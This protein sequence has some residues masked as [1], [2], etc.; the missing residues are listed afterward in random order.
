M[1]PFGKNARVCFI[2]DSI[3]NFNIYVAYIYD[4][5]AVH[6]AA[7]NVR[8]YNCGISGA[9]AQTLVKAY[10]RDVMP[11][12][13]THAVIMAGVN[14]CGRELLQKEIT[15]QAYDT[16]RARLDGYK[17]SI[18]SLCGKAER[19]NAR[20]ILCT[21]PPI[22]EYTPHPAPTFNGGYALMAAYADFIRKFAKERKY[23]LCDVFARLSQ[24][25]CEN[26]LYGDDRIHPNERGQACIAK[27][28]LAA[29]GE[30]HDEHQ[31]ISEK[32][33]VWRDRVFYY[34]RIICAEHLILGGFDTPPDEGAAEMREF[35]KNKSAPD[36]MRKMAEIYIK[37][38]PRQAALEKEAYGE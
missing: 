4:Y 20:V 38:K 26:V 36:F 25:M 7:D 3:T 10:E 32:S 35:L 31:H 5:Y 33:A 30:K 13:P 8:F 17:Q 37:E 27:C 23:G 21:P 15:A 34:R 16:L 28:I 22:D 14:D 6:H 19:G 9:G 12:R 2:G 18:A 24:E 1:Q 29:Q 11:H